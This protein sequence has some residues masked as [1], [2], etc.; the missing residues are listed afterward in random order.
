MQQCRNVQKGQW[1]CVLCYHNKYT[2]R[3]RVSAG[4]PVSGLI[5][6]FYCNPLFSIYAWRCEQSL[7]PCPPIQPSSLC[8]VYRD[9]FNN[10][11]RSNA[12]MLQIICQLVFPSWCDCK[13]GLQSSVAARVTVLLQFSSIRWVNGSGHPIRV[14]LPCPGTW[15]YLSGGSTVRKQDWSPAAGQAALATVCLLDLPRGPWL[16]NVKV[17]IGSTI[18]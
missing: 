18:L 9:R 12:N 14:P 15:A 8:W 17:L 3:T 11:H 4:S 5:F 2:A 6:F 1:F 7:C 10:W 13:S 16:C